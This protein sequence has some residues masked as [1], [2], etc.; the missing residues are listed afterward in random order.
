MSEPTTSR[1]TVVLVHGAF[2]DS[3]S[4]N[5]VVA[6]LQ[7]RGV[8]VTAVANPLRTLSGD[9]RY[10]A[11]VLASI[12]GPVVLVGHS[13]GGSVI[14]QAAA[15]A[16]NVAALVYVAA[17]APADGESALELSGKFP[18]STLGDTLKSYPLTDGGTEL[19]IRQDAF[20]Q[21]FAAD[22]D[23]GTAALMAAGQR[24]ATSAALGEGLAAGAPAWERL[25][26]TFV[27]A[28]ADRNIPAEAV[29]FMA[30]RAGGRLIEIAGASHA[31]AVSHPAE[32]AD[33]VLAA[34]ADVS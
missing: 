8:P 10:V 29:R 3:S 26:S 11:D 15:D 28:G 30:D 19:A 23:P 16:T 4:W 9:G 14:T 12:P 22:V 27:L 1:P 5:G 31:V 7:A 18:G 21:Q 34:V 32:V 24:P 6:R 20:A 33:A 13:Y 25:P 2:A 17:F